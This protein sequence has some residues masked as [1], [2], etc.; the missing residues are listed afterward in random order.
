MESNEK[1][2]KEKRIRE[3]TL[4]YYSMPEIRKAIFE[5]AQNR[6]TVPRYFEG[7]GKRPDSFQYDSDILEHVKRGATSFHCSEELWQ[8]PLEI[9]TDMSPQ[10]LNEIKTGWDLLLDIDS[11]YLE[12][13]KIYAD[14]LIRTL[15]FYGIKNIGVK[16]SGSKGFHIIIPWKAFPKEIY[17][18][19]TKDMFP[20][21]PRLICEY[22][23]EI[24]QPKLADKIFEEESLKDLAKK[25][26]KKEEE[27]LITECLSCHRPATK[28]ELVTWYCPYCKSE[29]TKIRENKRIPKCPNDSCR[30]DLIEKTKQQISYCEFCNINS[31]KNPE[32]FAKT[33]EKTEKLIEAD[34]ILVAPRHLFRMPYSL[35]EKTSLSSIVLDKDKILNFQIT[36]AK[37]FKVKVKKYYP[38]AKENEAKELL[39]QALDWKEQRT[40]KEEQTKQTIGKIDLPSKPN[41]NKDFQKIQITNPSED[42]FPPCIK[43]ILKGIPQDGRKRA[44]FLLLN[45]FK[46]LGMSDREIETKIND[47]N[48]KN[49]MPL[50]QGYINSQLFWYQKNQARLPPNCDKPNYKDLGFC[51]PDELCRQIKNPLNYAMKKYFRKG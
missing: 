16:F 39:L 7:F 27:L 32:L 19:K 51:K 3:I 10:Q 17:G 35:H 41:K 33:R 2:I 4:I 34:L 36:D 24:L 46:S 5:F 29:L 44:L 45:F 22:L 31:N 1:S 42:I 18:Q 25:T 14:L 40:Q 21:W 11:P 28:K 8:D 37:P 48:K 20:E 13:S 15:N 49:A 38:E 6:E 50:K 26:G 9:S 23:T 30:K 12:Y 47:W 43:I